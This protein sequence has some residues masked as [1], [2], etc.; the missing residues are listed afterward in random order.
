VNSELT[1]PDT[2]HTVGPRLMAQ[3]VCTRDKGKN[4]IATGGGRKK[5]A[6]KLANER[7]RW[8]R[9]LSGPS[10]AHAASR[11]RFNRTQKNSNRA[12]RTTDTDKCLRV[13][14]AVLVSG[15]SGP[16]ACSFRDKSLASGIRREASCGEL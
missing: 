5:K 16:L 12:G 2:E 6:L 3:T 11:K 1:V 15:L 7:A 9:L 14:F 10:P 8:G 4:Q 13:A